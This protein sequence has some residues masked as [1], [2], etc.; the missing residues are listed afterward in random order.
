MRLGRVEGLTPGRPTAISLTGRPIR[1]ANSVPCRQPRWSDSDQTGLILQRGKSVT[2]HSL[3]GIAE[4]LPT[5]ERRSAGLSPPW[6]KA[7]AVSPILWWDPPQAH[8]T[9]TFTEGFAPFAVN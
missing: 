5:A 6:L 7:G 8:V 9:V 3:L 4:R 1:P 2:S